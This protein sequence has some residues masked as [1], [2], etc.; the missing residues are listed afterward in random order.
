MAK[1]E[2]ELAFLRDLDINETWTK[3]FTDL[4]DKHVGFKKAE[5]ILYINAGTGDH[6]IAVREKLNEKTE[7]FAT[8]ENDE[9][10]K[11][12]RDKGAAVRANIDF[13]EGDLDD[14]SF[15]V[16]VADASFAQADSIEE[17]ITDAVRV[18]RPG[19]EVAV[20]LPSAGSFG[21][22][23][24]LL[25]EVF[26]SEELGD[27]TNA[28]ETLIARI[29]S[30]SR[31]E[32]IASNAG[33]TEVKTESTK[34]VFENENGAEFIGSPLVADFLL[35]VWFETLDEDQAER[36]TQKLSQL[37]DDEDGDLAFRFSVKAT[38]V[39]GKKEHLN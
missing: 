22:V 38:L 26:F 24:S 19:G 33:L 27:E 30:I 21:E 35:P 13:P 23:F 28:A 29:P 2:R 34:E 16:V 31:I 8:C 9:L 3:R 6:C 17:L 11:I 20:V 12:A 37:I 7:M 18:A 39:S 14:D 10:L 5:K 1:T 15:D 32:E 4:L 36:A 25:W